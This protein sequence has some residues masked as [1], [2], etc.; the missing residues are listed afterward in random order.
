MKALR[1]ASP[2]LRILANVVDVLAVNLLPWLLSTLLWPEDPLW[3]P[4]AFLFGAAYFTYFT[5]SDWQAT[6]GQRLFG[7]HVVRMQGGRMDRR[8]A[9]VRFLAYAMPEL[10]KYLNSIPQEM[11][12]Q[13]MMF[14]AVV[15]FLPII[16]REDKRG[17]HDMFSDSRVVAGKL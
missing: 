9:A 5:A 13:A 8:M 11:A 3:I 4:V 6:P 14:L 15:W 17:V 16:V 12:A 10:P 2:L 7:L 1:P